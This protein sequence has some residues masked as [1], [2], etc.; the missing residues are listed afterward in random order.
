MEF[1]T[2]SEILDLC[3][4]GLLW[5]LITVIFT[6]QELKGEARNHYDFKVVR[7]P[8]VC[9]GFNLIKGF[10]AIGQIFPERSIIVRVD[11]ILGYFKLIL[12]LACACGLFLLAARLAV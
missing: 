8:G 7:I 1:F 11:Y 12:L 6:T 5:F 2:P 9:Y 10:Q 3:K 4:R